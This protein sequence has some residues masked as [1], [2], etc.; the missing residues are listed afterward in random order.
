IS[1]ELLKADASL[2]YTVAYN[3]NQ[4]IDIRAHN[5][6][7]EYT[8][9]LLQGQSDLPGAQ[10]MEQLKPVW[11]ADTGDEPDA[12]E[13]MSLLADEQI[14]SLFILPISL[15]AVPTGS[16][17]LGYKQPQFFDENRLQLGMTLAQTLAIIIQ[18]A[19][20]Y[21]A[22]RH[23]YKLAEALTRAAAS[24]NSTLDLEAVFDEILKQILQVVPCQG[25]NI[26]MIADDLTTYVHRHSGYEEIPGYNEV[27]QSIRIPTSTPNIKTVLKGD[28][29]L[30][31]DT[32]KDPDWVVFPEVEWIKSC[33]G[34]PLK[35]N[36]EVVGL[37][38]VDSSIPGFFTEET[39]YRLQTFANHAAIAIRNAN[40]YQQ[41]QDHAADLETRVQKRTSELWAAKEHIEGILASV[42]DA[43]FVLDANQELVQVNHAG[44][45]LLDQAKKSNQ[46]LFDSTFLYPSRSTNLPEV[47]P[48]LELGDRAY[49]ARASEIVLD[50]NQPTGQVV[51]F[52]DVTRFRELDQLKTQFIS[53]V[54]HEL[55]TPLTNLTLYLGFLENDQVYINQRTYLD[56]LKRETTRLT[57][58]IEDL[59]A[60]SRIQV[61][62]IG[63]EIQPVRINQIVDQLV[64][65]RAFLAAQKDI[66]LASKS[67]SDLPLAMADANW[68]SQSL[69][70]LLTNAINYTPPGGKVSLQTKVKARNQQN[71]IVIEVIDNGV[72]IDPDEAPYI[73]DRFYRGSAS[74]KTGAVGTGLGLAI[75]NELVKRMGGEISFES[76]LDEGSIFSIYLRPVIHAML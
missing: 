48:L 54:S 30:I 21:Q 19:R 64:I 22:E 33:V 6:S 27:I 41:L 25:A 56:I 60:F 1:E 53:D 10:A 35:I 38:S 23:Q 58:L 47:H 57:H 36:Q 66:R 67:L 15:D 5:I 51:V 2:I 12:G 28:P 20:L 3:S 13:W 69:S 34:I 14:R 39:V 43:V 9:C 50:E 31:T 55:R 52:R 17:L 49:Q 4:V 24:L 73:F 62:K 40:L 74:N 29:V 65:D 71:W 45:W 16:L 63:G 75:S 26:M 42:P 70:N 18:N 8:Q 32:H 72:G 44:K 37:L 11:I 46:D 76:T 59:L 7:Q 68:L 61:S